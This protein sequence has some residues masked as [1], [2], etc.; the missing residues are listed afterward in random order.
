M[1]KPGYWRVELDDG[2]AADRHSTQAE[3]PYVGQLIF[4]AYG[5]TWRVDRVGPEWHAHA[6]PHE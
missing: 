1:V 5:R 6:V 4:K 3:P 2:T